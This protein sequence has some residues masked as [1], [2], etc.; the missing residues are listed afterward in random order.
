MNK[1]A[2]YSNAKQYFRMRKAGNKLRTILGHE[3]RDIECKVQDS[4]TTLAG[5]TNDLLALAKRFNAQQKNSKDQVCALHAIKVVCIAKSKACSPYK[6]SKM[7]S[8]A[9]TAKDS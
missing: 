2:G 9:V 1:A 7:V 4:N 8:I 5:K 3:V 6:F